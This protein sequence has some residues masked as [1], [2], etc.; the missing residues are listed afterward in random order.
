MKVCLREDVVNI[1]MKGDIV[2][3]ADGYALNYLIPRKLAV[4]VTD[5]NQASLSK[6][7]KQEERKKEVIESK[8]SMLAER[9]K[10]LE[11]VLRRKMHEG[12][13]LYGS[14][15]PSEIVDLL[16]AKGISVQ[17]NQIEV[18]KTIKSKGSYP[19]TIKLS[20][21][22]KPTFTLRIVAE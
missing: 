7:K 19:I 15:H 13:K 10:S 2:K 11:L 17:K 16:A 4:V 14:I 1:G 18:D 5:E 12:D 6:L 21:K 22:L 9:I 3:V 8:S 20:T